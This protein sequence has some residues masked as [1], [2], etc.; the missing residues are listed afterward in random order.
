M[1]NN[2]LT[3]VLDK[4]PVN[5]EFKICAESIVELDK[6]WQCCE[7]FGSHSIKIR[8]G[9]VQGEWLVRI[10]PHHVVDED[11]YSGDVVQGIVSAI[12]ICA[13][14]YVFMGWLLS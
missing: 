11:E 1:Q 4:S 8:G 12:G 3:T 9:Y 14:F 6:A 7:R 2:Y 13:V 10:I 5:E